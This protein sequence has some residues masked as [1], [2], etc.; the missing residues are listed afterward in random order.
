M[1]R[2]I[3]AAAALFAMVYYTKFLDRPDL[4]HAYQ[5]Y[6]AAL[7]VI[8]FVVY[9]ASVIADAALRRSR[10]RPRI[11]AKARCSAST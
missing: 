8:A 10:W 2:A 1:K 7:P 11:S 4:G 3:A 6:G 5:S 9:R